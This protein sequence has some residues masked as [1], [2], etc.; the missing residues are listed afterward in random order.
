MSLY[1]VVDK[2]LGVQETQ[3]YII[4][5]VQE[6]LSALHET[7]SKID[8][9]VPV[10]KERILF[11]IVSISKDNLDKAIKTTMSIIKELTDDYNQRYTF[12]YE[13]DSIEDNDYI[14][15]LKKLLN[16]FLIYKT[17]RLFNNWEREI[18]EQIKTE[19]ITYLNSTRYD[20]WRDDVN[21][22]MEVEF[23]W[24]N[25]REE[26]S[27]RER[28][29]KN[30]ETFQYVSS[31][32]KPPAYVMNDKNLKENFD[33]HI[34]FRA[35]IDL[36][37]Y[38]KALIYSLERLEFFL[39]PNIS[40]FEDITYDQM[41]NPLVITNAPFIKEWSDNILVLPKEF[42]IKNPNKITDKIFHILNIDAK[43]G[44]IPWSVKTKISNIAF[45]YI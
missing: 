6:V 36:W 3:V 21:R 42:E 11:D 32:K 8:R 40:G 26:D 34:I 15:R 29:E 20:G 9:I 25:K 23:I 38:E 16:G 27:Q 10:N 37:Q 45:K 44:Q 30:S 28:D 19:Q 33:Y 2:A 7:R 1:N 22:W 12:N 14:V 17:H 18:A 35:L 43:Y 13:L 24:N 41:Y 31:I 39:T 5:Y 4:P